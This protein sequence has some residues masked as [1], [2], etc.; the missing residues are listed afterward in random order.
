MPFRRNRRPKIE[1]ILS[2]RIEQDADGLVVIGATSLPD[3]TN[4]RCGIWRGEWAGPFNEI[5]YV[6]ATA[7]G[8]SIRARFDTPSWTGRTSA[9]IELVADRR[10]PPQVQSVIGPTGENLAYGDMRLPGE[11]TAVVAICTVNL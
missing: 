3:G 6:P 5:V 7:E 11:Y 10:Q 8:G 2:V 9:V 4:V 1:P